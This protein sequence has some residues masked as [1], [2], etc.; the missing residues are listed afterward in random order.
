ML[1][2]EEQALVARSLTSADHDYFVWSGLL[3]E[4]FLTGRWLSYFDGETAAVVGQPLAERRIGSGSA[5]EHITQ[6]IEG[7]AGREEV[8]FINYNGPEPVRELPPQQWHLLYACPPATCNR[9][10]FLNLR[11]PDQ[12]R[13][14]WEIRGQRRTAARRGLE[15]T[16]ARREFLGHEHIRLLR[17][18]A[19]TQE[20]GEKLFL[21][22]RTVEG[23]RTKILEKMNVKKTAGVV[24]FA[25]RH[26][27]ITE[28]ELL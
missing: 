26:H 13:F 18:L 22:K 20:I 4:P 25:L 17:D 6:I 24:I 1:S 12:G 2:S 3:G 15:V 8:V 11:A 28:N 16:V 21:S 5:G 10:V 23:Y 7:W 27:L 9:E 14:C 19:T